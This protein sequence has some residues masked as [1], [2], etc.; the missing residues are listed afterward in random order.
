MGPGC[1]DLEAISG[2]KTGELPTSG[3]SSLMTL[4]K[5][6]RSTVRWAQL[7]HRNGALNH[8]VADGL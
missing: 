1:R 7:N 2:L 4:P 3:A 6:S 8:D 5:L